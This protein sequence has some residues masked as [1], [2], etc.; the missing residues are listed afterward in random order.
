M[1]GNLKR[2]RHIQRL[3]ILHAA[4][5]ELID[6]AKA[7]PGHEALWDREVATIC[8]AI[9]HEARH[10]CN[11]NDECIITELLRNIKG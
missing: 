9:E 4:L 2:I 3:E 8:E 11:E 1:A 6:R 5:G 10:C 7:D